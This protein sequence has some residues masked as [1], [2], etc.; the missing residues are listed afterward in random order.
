MALDVGVGDGNHPWPLESEP[1][2]TLEDDGYYWF[3]YPLVT[4]L[5]VETGEYINPYEFASFHGEALHAL[6]R[7]IVEARGQMSCQPDTWSVHLG[8]QV[9]PE[10]KELYATVEKRQF[11]TLLDQWDEIIDRA[12][13]LEQAVV[14]YGD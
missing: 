4:R 11:L 5:R 3:L 14:C 7:M 8:T 13:E 12:K 10:R 2:L 9:R 1:A 6:K